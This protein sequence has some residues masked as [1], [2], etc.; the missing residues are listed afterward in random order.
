[1][2]H[3]LRTYTGSWR[4]S[5]KLTHSIHGHS[6][7]WL[8]AAGPKTLPSE[9]EI[10]VCWRT[11]FLLATSIS[12]FSSVFLTFSPL[13]N[14]TIHCFP[15]ARSPLQVNLESRGNFPSNSLRCFIMAHSLLP[16]FLRRSEL[17]DAATSAWVQCPRK[18]GR[19]Q[20]IQRPGR[21][22]KI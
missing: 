9:T 21:R 11:M 4:M 8:S 5:P 16:I 15:S 20:R 18:I 1:M 22:P 3:F 17:G 19:G 6:P 12:T 2:G 14:R 10:W 7:G 13:G